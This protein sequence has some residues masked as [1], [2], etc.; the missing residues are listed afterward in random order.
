MIYY[1]SK[2]K[3]HYFGISMDV[4]TRKMEYLFDSADY[5]YQDPRES[6]VNG[7]VD[8]FGTAL[9]HMHPGDRWEIWIP[10]QLGYGSTGSHNASGQQTVPWPYST[11]KFE[12]EVV[13]VIK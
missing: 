3:V 7:V 4:T 13:E 10:W 6:T 1:T 12:V 5:P 11:L 9:Q 8:G 2:V